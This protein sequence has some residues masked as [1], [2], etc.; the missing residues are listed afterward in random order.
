MSGHC[1]RVFYTDLCKRLLTLGFGSCGTVRV[2]RKGLPPFST[3]KMKKG[4]VI[5]FHDGQLTGVKWMDKHPVAV[6]STIHDDSMTTI[7]RRTR[8]SLGSAETISKPTIITEYTKFMGGVDVA[9]Q[10]VT[11]YGFTHCSKKWWKRAFFHLFEVCM[12][13]A[14]I[15]HSLYTPNRRHTHMEF[16]LLVAR[17]LLQRCGLE[18]SAPPQPALDQPLRLVGRNHFPEPS[19]K[20][21]D[22]R[23]CSNRSVKRKQTSYQCTTCKVPLCIH[24]CFKRYHTLKEYK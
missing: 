1:F 7:T 16:L 8:S 15:L 18:S 10:L 12:V 9:D 4:E 14:Y 11:Y 3:K 20:K 6:L 24:P 17:Q 13:N 22:C 19:G 2:N 21:R 23:V 5:T